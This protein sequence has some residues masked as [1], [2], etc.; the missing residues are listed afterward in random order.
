MKMI[1][2]I[3]TPLLIALAISMFTACSDSSSNSEESGLNTY[4]INAGEN[5]DVP[6]DAEIVSV[7]SEDAQ[8]KLTRDVEA[9]TTNVHVISGSV[10]VTQNSSLE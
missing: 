7:S 5:R 9:D 1:Q 6:T 8:V 2:T 3:L 10:E 4:I